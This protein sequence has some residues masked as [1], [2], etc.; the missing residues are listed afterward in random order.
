VVIYGHFQSWAQV[1]AI[2]YLSRNV[3]R[4][5]VYT[6]VLGPFPLWLYSPCGPWPLFQFLNYIHD[7]LCGLVVRVSGY[8]CPG[9]D[10]RRY[11]IFWEVV[12]LER[13]SLSLV[14]II[15]ELL[16]RTVAAPVWKT[17][18]NGRGNLLRWPWHNLYQRKLALTSPT[19]GG[20]LVGIVDWRLSPGV[21]FNVIHSR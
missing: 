6:F 11:Q 3:V 2:N 18:I 17:E 21:F 13:G 1:I 10:S 9:F 5:S 15:E 8:R 19:S 12:S 4:L 16:E 14:T 20:L 7:L